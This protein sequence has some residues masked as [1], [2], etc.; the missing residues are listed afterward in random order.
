MSVEEVRRAD[1]EADFATWRENQL[2]KDKEIETKAQR[3]LWKL[4]R[5]RSKKSSGRLLRDEARD[6]KILR[7]I[8]S[9][10]RDGD[11]VRITSRGGPAVTDLRFN[12]KRTRAPESTEGRMEKGGSVE[13]ET[14][15]ERKATT[16]WTPSWDHAGDAMK[17]LAWSQV[18]R[19]KRGKALTLHLSEEVVSE[20]R[21][22]SE[23]GEKS[24]TE[25]I[26]DRVSQQ[27][28]KAFAGTQLPMPEFFFV[29]ETAYGKSPH[30]HG[31][32]TVP[33]GAEHRV[34]AA[35]IKAGGP[36][37]TGARQLQLTEITSAAGWV[38]YCLK[39]REQ[40]KVL[41]Q[42]SRLVAATRGLRSEARAWYVEARRVGTPIN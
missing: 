39:W 9:A 5:L 41:L 4:R 36:W 30:L 34:R 1:I 8:N 28:R 27:L 14:R 12:K 7:K 25:F 18:M 21:R 38:S 26:R 2:R 3:L 17:L 33:S 37:G 40:A 29:I 6:D 32:I 19:L 10:L 35:L 42:D 23:A 20:G 13:R 11:L 22:K 15:P 24:F 31:A 16:L